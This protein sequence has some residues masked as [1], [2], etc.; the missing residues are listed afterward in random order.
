MPA[1]FKPIKAINNPIP[2]GIAVIITLGI[3]PNIFSLMDTPF[4]LINDNMINRIPLK[5]TIV[6][7]L[8]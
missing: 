5:N 1:F 2:T 6:I 3:P 7:T 4:I 8:L